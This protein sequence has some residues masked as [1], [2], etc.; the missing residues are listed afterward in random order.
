MCIRDRIKVIFFGQPWVATDL[1]V[2]DK[3][4]LSGRVAYEK[5]KP[6][7]KSP[8]YE[9][10]VDGVTRLH[11]GRLVPVYALS[12][13]IN[14]KPLR[15]QI[16]GA[17]RAS[18]DQLTEYMPQS[19]L[20]RTGLYS[21]KKAVSRYHFPKD[22]QDLSRARRR[23]AFDELFFIQLLMRKKKLDWKNKIAGIALE[24]NQVLLEEIFGALPFK[25][26]SAQT[27]GVNEIS[28]DMSSSIP[29]RR[30]LQ[31]DVGSGKTLVALAGMIQASSKG[32]Q[33]ALMV[34]TEVLSE[35]HF[36]TLQNFFSSSP[37]KPLIEGLSNVV[38]TD[39]SG[40]DYKLTIALLNGSLRKREKTMPQELIRS[41][42]AD[43]IVGTQALIQ[44]SVDIPNLA[45]LVVDEQHRFGVN[46]KS[47]FDRLDPRPHLLL[48][49]AT[50][51]PR[52]LYFTMIGDL[53]LSVIDQMPVGR[54]PVQT[55]VY[56]KSKRDEVYRFIRK[57]ILDG[58]Q[59]FV[60]CPLI[61]ESESLQSKA[62]MEEYESLSK[63]VFPEMKVGL[64]HGR[65]K[66][67]EKEA[68]MDL[69]RSGYIHILVAT[70]VIEV[71]IDVPNASIML[72]DGAERFG[73]SQLHQFRGRVGRGEHQSYCILMSDNPSEDSKERMDILHRVNDGFRLADEDL[74]MRGAG[75]L[76]LIHI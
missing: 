54:K 5:G 33:S 66:L 20:Q 73:L 16:Y 65:M 41:G 47:V 22:I 55:H 76:S 74:R 21:L 4:I 48:M 35:Q 52:S 39:I 9:R 2:G 34:P 38:E 63:D 60:V 30:V 36:M 40:T 75:E 7:Y 59:A 18:V 68:V 1:K 15:R 44:D 31:G 62:A 19:I 8:I 67:S 72:I 11:T 45:F 50:P 58:R 12:Q 51:I 29:M 57:E 23:I 56:D 14:I 24:R 64:L 61:E 43:M 46:Q 49:S 42:Q 25:L 70:A 71:G 17:L 53:D 13:G 37:P 10:I 69:F 3:V 6:V 32:Y 28:E 27:R 26:T